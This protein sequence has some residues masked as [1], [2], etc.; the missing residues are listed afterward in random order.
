MALDRLP[1]Q[2]IDTETACLASVLLSREA[3]F[4]V[5]EILQP[6]DFYLEKNRIIYDAIVE[7][8]R[9]NLPIDLTTLKQ[10][11]ADSK[12]FDLVGGD[13]A[14]VA[15][16]QS[17]ST[18]ANAEF[19]ARRIKELSLRRKLIDVNAES[20]EKCFDSTRDTI[21]L[22]DEIEQDIFRVTEKRISSD[23]KPIDGVLLETLQD[24]GRWFETKRVVTGIAS[25]FRRLDEV[26]TGFHGSELI[27]V[28]ARPGMGKTAFAL[29]L[30]VNA[31][32]KEKTAVMFFSLEM[33]A[34][35]LAMRMLCIEARVDSQKVR[36]GQ[37]TNPEMKKLI[38]ASEK[39][40]RASIFIDDTPSV[41]IMELRA[42]ARRLH[43][44]T[45][46]G[47]II[48]DYLQLVTTT[49]RV[50]RHLQVAEISRLLKQLA[51]ELNVPVIAAAQLSRA[52]ETRT[53]QIPTLAD[54]RESGSIEQDADVVM[55]IYRE[56]KVK[57]DSERMGEAD[58]I[59]AKQRNG[60]TDTIPLKFWEQFTR[61]DNLERIHS[62]EE[63]VPT[64]ALDN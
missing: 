6:E 12:R 63:A 20:I 1:P 44:K 47:L 43:Q 41:S 32:I 53:T 62:M 48:V 33:P 24:I 38:Q 52:V 35:Q 19:Y 31:A 51:R 59:V 34:T 46:L 13:A 54:L 8:E 56:E 22:I 60:P 18:S 11:L 15:L 42:K 25:G 4:K 5:T 45:Q 30:L 23:Y 2:D 36:T 64:H 27:I 16:Y 39:L 17:A 50:D 7:L 55:F 9:K 28:A 37:I 49:S 61:F 3:L 26:L 10:R 14:L 57:K 40:S 29:N 21:E 58:I